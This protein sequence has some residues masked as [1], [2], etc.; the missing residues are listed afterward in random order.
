METE[1]VNVNITQ[2]VS[3]NTITQYYR[4]QKDKQLQTVHC[5]HKILLAKSAHKI[6]KTKNINSKI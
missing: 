5:R 3:D 6:N 2:A 1:Q 4:T